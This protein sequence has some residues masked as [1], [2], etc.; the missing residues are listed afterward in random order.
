MPKLA[1]GSRNLRERLNEVALNGDEHVEDT[2]GT[3]DTASEDERPVVV[4]AYAT[5]AEDEE[6]HSGNS[7]GSGNSSRPAGV[8]NES[9]E[10]LS[11]GTSDQCNDPHGQ[12]EDSGVDR[13]VVRDLLP[14]G[15]K[16]ELRCGEPAEQTEG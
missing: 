4:P 2:D 11:E 7:E 14:V 5:I 13:G 1:R 15:R 3:D 16:A 6:D 8:G 10:H 9:R 12:K